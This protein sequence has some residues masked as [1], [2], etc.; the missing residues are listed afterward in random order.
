MDDPDEEAEEHIL[1][2]ED[3]ILGEQ[4]EGFEVIR[5]AL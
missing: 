5:Y 1:K 2:V 4:A 3:S